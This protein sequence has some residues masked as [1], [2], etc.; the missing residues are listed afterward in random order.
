MEKVEKIEEE[1]TKPVRYVRLVVGLFLYALG[2]VI[3]INAD[4]GYA[5]WDVFHQGISNVTGIKIGTANVFVGLTILAIGALNGQRPG[6]GTISNMIL[7]GNFVNLIMWAD[8]LPIFSNLYIRILTLPIALL[9]MS[10]GVYL[11]IS[12]AFGAGPRDGVMIML[13]E[14][15]GR[16]ITFVRNAIEMTALLVG[17]LLGGP[18]GIGTV[19]LSVGTGY[20]LEFVFDIFDF[21]TSDVE[22][23]DWYDIVESVKTIFGK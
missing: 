4:L 23:S 22:H 8:V 6:I 1:R 18:V 3:S 17:Y 5:P 12:S 11:Y 20:A 16:S 10:L 7:I 2:V 21:K 19:I 15:T 9:T 14:K 13:H